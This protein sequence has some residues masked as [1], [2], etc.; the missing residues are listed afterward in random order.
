VNYR[1]EASQWLALSIGQRLIKE[2]SMGLAGGVLVGAMVIRMAV[3]PA[4]MR[5][6]GRANWWFPR[7]LT[8]G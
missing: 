8:A 6:L 2:F 7:G 1:Y 5:L 4:V 3:V